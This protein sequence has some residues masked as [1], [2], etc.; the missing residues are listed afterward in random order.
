ML[1]AEQCLLKSY[2]LISQFNFAH[3]PSAYTYEHSSLKNN[4]DHPHNDSTFFPKVILSWKIIQDHS[5]H[6]RL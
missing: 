6:I 5:S 1:I 4:S 2:L 3:I